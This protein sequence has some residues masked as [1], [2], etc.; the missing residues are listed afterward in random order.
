MSADAV[1]DLAQLAEQVVVRIN[2]RNAAE[3]KIL[4]ALA[5]IE[6]MASQFTPVALSTEIDERTVFVLALDDIRDGVSELR[7]LGQP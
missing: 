5:I 3:A 6:P 2:R 4:N 7:D 1:G